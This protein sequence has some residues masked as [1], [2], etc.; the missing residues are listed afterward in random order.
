[1][2]DV[3]LAVLVGEPQ[4]HFI[5]EHTQEHLKLWDLHTHDTDA[6]SPLTCACWVL[7]MAMVVPSV[8]ACATR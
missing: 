1:M 5:G 7:S 8:M 4:S 2:K 3:A 6:T